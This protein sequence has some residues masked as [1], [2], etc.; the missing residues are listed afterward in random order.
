MSQATTSAAPESKHA[1][2]DGEPDH[3]EAGDE[4]EEYEDDSA[5]SLVAQGTLAFIA[6]PHHGEI[7]EVAT[8]HFSDPSNIRNA[9]VLCCSPDDLDAADVA[10]KLVCM[11]LF[12]HRHRAPGVR[13]GPRLDREAE[14]R[15]RIAELVQS[16]EAES[17]AAASRDEGTTAE[18]REGEGDE[19]RDLDTRPEGQGQDEDAGARFT[20]IAKDVML[21]NGA[22][23]VICAPHSQVKSLKRYWN[24]RSAE[25]FIAIPLIF[26]DQIAVMHK[27]EAGGVVD[28]VY[29]GQVE[30][31]GPAEQGGELQLQPGPTGHHIEQEK[32]AGDS[33]HAVRRALFCPAT[34]RT[35]EMNTIL[36]S[37]MVPNVGVGKIS[38]V[39]NFKDDFR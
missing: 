17:G 35:S 39:S 10:D 21:R 28:L 22:G 18:R 33:V 38:P 23:L 15:L 20:E 19:E 11:S 30:E 12:A 9:Q 1:T 29:H 2:E 6:G 32:N 8:P 25:I 36:H 5:E 4:L 24:A 13:D 14:R 27:F 7:L 16:M 31:T 37:L 3:G 34:Q 26:F